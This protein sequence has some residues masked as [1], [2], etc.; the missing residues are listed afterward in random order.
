[1]GITVRELIK[2]LQEIQDEQPSEDANVEV[3]FCPFGESELIPLL[4]IEAGECGKVS[5]LETCVML[6]GAE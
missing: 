5:D 1:M 2:Q 3:Y 6:N 4:N